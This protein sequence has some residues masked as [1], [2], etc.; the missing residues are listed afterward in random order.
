[1]ESNKSS[2]LPADAP[3]TIAVMPTRLRE[4]VQRPAHR[5]HTVR[6]ISFISSVKVVSSMTHRV[7]GVFRNGAGVRTA[8]DMRAFLMEPQRRL[9]LSR[10]LVR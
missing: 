6:T 4:E 10:W 3:V 9:M 5:C 2:H 1:M 8:L 7:L